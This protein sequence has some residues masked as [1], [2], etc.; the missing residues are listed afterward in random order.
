[1]LQRRMQRQSWPRQTGTASAHLLTRTYAV[2]GIIKFLAACVKQML[3]HGH[4][5]A[6]A[7]LCKDRLNKLPQLCSKMVAQ[8]RQQQAAFSSK[9]MVSRQ[10]PGGPALQHKHLQGAAAMGAGLDHAMPGG[11]SLTGIHILQRG[12]LPKRDA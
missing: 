2:Q 4:E 6:L 3:Q 12:G 7:L 11:M 5:H 8:V 10:K 1:M 9:E